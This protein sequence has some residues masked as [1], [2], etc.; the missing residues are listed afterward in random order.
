[1]RLL[2]V[3]PAPYGGL[4]H[5]MVQLAD[6]LA[7][8]G[9]FVDL[10]VARDNE[11]VGKSRHARMLAELPQLV[12]GSEPPPAGPSYRRRQARVALRLVRC[13]ARIIAEG[14]RADHD[15]MILG[16]DTSLIPTAAAALLLTTVPGRPVLARISHNART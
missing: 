12:N 14:R 6:A 9:H 13:W 16:A 10:L 15:A 4:L 2:L 1:M 8:R 5:Y 11:V 3:E 7:D